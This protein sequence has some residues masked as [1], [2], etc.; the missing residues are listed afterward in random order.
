MF[1]N[2]KRARTNLYNERPTW[3]RLAHGK[4]TAP[5]RPPAPPST[6]LVLVGRGDSLFACHSA[7]S[8]LA[9]VYVH[10]R[11][12]YRSRTAQ[13]RQVRYVQHSVYLTSIGDE[14]IRTLDLRLAN[15]VKIHAEK[16]RK[17]LLLAYF[18][19]SESCCKRY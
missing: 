15:P 4:L 10:P 18:S 5:C 3:S 16:P 6:C 13:R 2:K 7:A 17:A 19:T 8:V 9:R 12:K 14:G 11:A 1:L